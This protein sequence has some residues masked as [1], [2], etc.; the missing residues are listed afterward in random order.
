MSSESLRVRFLPP[1]ITRII[2]IVVAFISLFSVFAVIFGVLIG[3]SIRSLQYVRFEIEGERSITLVD[4]R[5]ATIPSTWTLPLRYL[6]I[7]AGVS[8]SPD[9]ASLIVMIYEGNRYHYGLFEMATS[10]LRT[11]V[12]GMTRGARPAWSPNSTHIAYIDA[13]ERLCVLQ[14]NLRESHPHC[15]EIRPEVLPTWSPSGEHIAVIE[16][17][18]DSPDSPQPYQLL[19]LTSDGRPTTRYPLSFDEISGIAWSPDGQYIA[20]SATN[21]A[22][23]LTIGAMD[24]TR[25]EQIR[26]TWAVF[27]LDLTSEQVVQRSNPGLYVYELSWSPDGSQVAFVMD[28]Q[29]NRDIYT[30][31]VTGQNE[32]RRITSAPTSESSPSWSPDSRWLAFLS[33]EDAAPRAYLVDLDATDAQPILADEK[34]IFYL[35]WRP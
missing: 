21:P 34:Y 12:T 15:L 14:V 30:I 6:N 32:M 35:L 7:P 17:V 18:H 3:R 31:D 22:S 16:Q 33:Q 13:L 27:T 24:A 1:L 11:V 28:Y 23:T 26:N 20:F 10:D 5:P 19:I 8:W 4:S 25:L 2:L 29:R 9:G